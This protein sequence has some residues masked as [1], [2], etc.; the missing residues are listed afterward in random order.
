MTDQAE[1]EIIRRTLDESR[2]NPAVQIVEI[3]A[4]LENTDPMSLPTMYDCVDGMLDN[5]FAQPP[6][7][8]AQMT[9]EFSYTL[10]RITVEQDG[11]A[12]FVKIG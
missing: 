7:P 5:L 11:T 10:Y 8:E 9:V 2:D 3:V 12:K 4:E 6:S 1:S